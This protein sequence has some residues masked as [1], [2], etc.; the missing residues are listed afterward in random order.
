MGGRVRRTLD[1]GD[2]RLIVLTPANLD[3]V[4]IS[5]DVVQKTERWVLTGEVWDTRGP[6]DVMVRR[7]TRTYD[8]GGE[9]GRKIAGMKISL[10]RELGR[11][12]KRVEG[13]N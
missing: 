11:A 8:Q 12:R 1:L 13:G 7:L 10:Y 3:D 9:P 4:K 5:S 2:Y 6:I